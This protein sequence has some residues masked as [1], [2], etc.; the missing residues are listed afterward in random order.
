MFFPPY[1]GSRS[2]VALTGTNNGN[3]HTH[4]RLERSQCPR[5]AMM[6]TPDKRSRSPQSNQSNQ[7]KPS[8]MGAP[9]HAPQMAPAAAPVPLS[10]LNSDAGDDDSSGDEEVIESSQSQQS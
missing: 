4:T 6:E 2:C 1:I 5:G 9:Q 8:A 10:R 3:T 7:N